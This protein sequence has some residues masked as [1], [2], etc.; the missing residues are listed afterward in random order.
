MTSDVLE[1]ALDA[2]FTPK[3]A[4]KGTGLG[5]STIHDFTKRSGGDLAIE[6]SPGKGTSVRIYLPRQ[7]SIACPSAGSAEEGRPAELP[8]VG[9]GEVVLVVED[10][11][12]VRR[13]TATTLRE[14]GYRVI[15]A[16][17]A[18]AALEAL[19]QARE[20][21]LLFTD[22]VMPGDRKSTRLNSSHYCASRMPSSA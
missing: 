13:V 18:T 16:A 10:E 3:G 14:L 7:D 8:V 4:G 1:R 12:P 2:F 9:G 21:R 22:I 6:S 20:V 19:E 11:E 15:E 5:L 17:T